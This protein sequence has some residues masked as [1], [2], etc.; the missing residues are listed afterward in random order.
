MFC[1]QPPNFVRS[2]KVLL[3]CVPIFLRR[4]FRIS[5]SILL[6]CTEA[7]ALYLSPDIYENSEHYLSCLYLVLKLLIN[8]KN[9]L[10]Q[11]I[12]N[13]NVQTNYLRI[14]SK[15]QLRVNYSVWGLA[16]F[17]LNKF[18]DV[19]NT[20]YLRT[21]LGVAKIYT[22]SFSEEKNLTQTWF[23]NL[24]SHRYLGPLS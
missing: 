14:L 1:L 12:S 18:P 15:S 6:Q 5:E 8:Y 24:N 11:C 16:F 13:T 22:T 9:G 2:Y 10:G 7:L 23:K 20:V 3:S 4:F 19:A 17:V 21:I